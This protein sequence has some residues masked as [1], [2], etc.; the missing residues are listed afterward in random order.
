MSLTLLIAACAPAIH[1]DTA[2][3]IVQHESGGYQYAIGINGQA[4]LTHKAQTK[5]QAVALATALIEGGGSIDLGYAQI[6]SKN[7]ARLQISIEQ[8]FDACTNLS[9]M[10]SILL[11]DYHRAASQ[12]GYGQT[13]LKAALS[14]YNTGNFNNG[15]RNGYVASVYRISHKTNKNPLNLNAV[16]INR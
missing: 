9:A 13:A 12:Y 8:A 15:I 7:L 14:S 1:P 6:N 3:S 2:M 16:A 10:Q 5:A 11:A 4:K